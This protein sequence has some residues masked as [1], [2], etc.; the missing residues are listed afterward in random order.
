ME[1]GF[2]TIDRL[3]EFYNN[4]YSANLMTAVLVSNHSLGHLEQLAYHKLSKITDN[5]RQ[6]LNFTLKDAFPQLPKIIS[7]I[8]LGDINK[9]SLYFPLT[10][11]E[12][13]SNLNY[14][15]FTYLERPLK[16][17]GKGSLYEL[18]VSKGWI[19]D[20]DIGKNMHNIAMILVEMQFELT[21]EGYNNIL[22]IIRMTF[23]AIQYYISEAVKEFTSR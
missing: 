7:H 9:L 12:I 16:Y 6:G 13:Y 4:Y 1:H 11:G 5:H 8:P 22:E 3:H 10:G 23:A 21:E 18:L 17:K 19:L 15:S 20:L 14:K 2:S